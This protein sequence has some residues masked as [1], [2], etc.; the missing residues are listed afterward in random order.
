M[1]QVILSL[2][3]IYL[4]KLIGYSNVGFTLFSSFLSSSLFLSAFS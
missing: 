2:K 3:V 1:I 4:G